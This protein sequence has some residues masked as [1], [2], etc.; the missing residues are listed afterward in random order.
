MLQ[1]KSRIVKMYVT[2]HKEHMAS[3][4]SILV[5]SR[6]MSMITPVI[7]AQKNIITAI[8]LKFSSVKIIKTANIRR[9]E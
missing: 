4:I 1:T 5:R 2:M 7:V 9:P 8:D 3:I 6:Q